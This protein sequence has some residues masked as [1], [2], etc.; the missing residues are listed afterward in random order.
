[1]YNIKIGTCVTTKF[2]TGFVV[3]NVLFLIKV[4]L[5]SGRIVNVSRNEVWVLE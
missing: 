5:D 3:D 1:M 2:G 4:A